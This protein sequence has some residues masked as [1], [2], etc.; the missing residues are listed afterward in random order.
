MA[1]TFVVDSVGITMLLQLD[2][3]EGHGGPVKSM[4]ATVD[5]FGWTTRISLAYDVAKDVLYSAS[6]GKTVKVW[7][8]SNLK[9]METIVAHNEAVNALAITPDR[10]LYSGSDDCT[11]KMWGS[12]RT[13]LILMRR[14]RMQYSSVKALALSVDRCHRH[15]VLCLS[16]M[17]K[18]LMFSGSADGTIRVWM[19]PVLSCL[20]VLQGYG[21]L[22]K[23]IAAIREDGYK[24][25]VFSG[26]PDGVI[27]VWCVRIDIV[28]PLEDMQDYSRL[29]K[30]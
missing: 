27:M 8:I 5:A 10:L 9:C 11:V 25:L 24:C 16:V 7:R 17:G 4:A 14:F 18:N 12:R 23:C 3:L 28:A 2:K 26:S 15:A 6:W 1:I 20:A 13:R 19:K 21:N 22:V 29:Y 30:G